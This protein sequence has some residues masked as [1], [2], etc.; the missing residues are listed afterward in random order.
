MN[1]EKFEE[2]LNNLKEK[3]FIDFKSEMYFTNSAKDTSKSRAE[4]VKDI[5]SMWNTPRNKE[6]YVVIGV[7]NSNN[8]NELLGIDVNTIPDDANLRNQ[9][10]GLVT[11]TP[12]FNYDTINFDKKNFVVITIPIATSICIV[13][14]K[15]HGETLK[16]DALYYRE[17]S[18][19]NEA[20]KGSEKE[21]EIY[22][23]FRYK[24]SMV[25]S[26]INVYTP[27]ERLTSLMENFNSDKYYYFLITS[28]LNSATPNLKNF[29]LV[30]W[31]F[32]MDFDPNSQNS[33]LLFHCRD[34]LELNRSLHFVVKGETSSIYNRYGTYWYF[35]SGLYGRNE[36]LLPDKSRNTWLRIYRRDF[37]KQ[38][39]KILKALGNEKPIKIL[40]VV[41]DNSI[42]DYLSMIFDSFESCHDGLSFLIISPDNYQS[43]NT[44]ASDRGFEFLTMPLLHLC[45]TF[46]NCQDNSNIKKE[47]YFIPSSSGTEIE[48]ANKKIP[49]LKE[50]FEIVHLGTGAT[51][52]IENI[53]NRDFLRGHEISWENL[54]FNHDAERDELKKLEHLVLEGLNNRRHLKINFYHI[55]G[56]GG[57]TVARRIL[58]NCHKK[59]PCVVLQSMK[60]PLETMMRLSHIYDI[61]QSSILLLIDGGLISDRQSEVLDEKI[62]SSHLPVITLQMIRRFD[63]QHAN[64]PQKNSRVLLDKLSKNEKD[65]FYYLLSK[66]ISDDKRDNLKKELK[67]DCTPF[68]LG[69]FI[70][71]NEYVGIDNYIKYRL[72]NINEINKKIIVFLSVAYYYGQRSISPQ[73]FSDIL[74][75]SSTRYIDLKDVFND[76]KIADIIVYDEFK[77]WRISHVIFAERCLSYLL[78]PQEFGKNN[79]H[80]WKQNL[81]DTAKEFI[82]FCR[83]NVH[84]SPSDESLEIIYRVFYF[85]DNSELLGTEKSE[86]SN[87]I[88]E[89]NDDN[90]KQ[91]VF[92]YLTDVF[93]DEAQFWAHLSRFYRLIK[94]DSSNALDAI[95]HALT[96]NDNDNLI[97]HGKGMVIWKKI[98]NLIYKNTAN[99]RNNLRQIVL[100]A[101]KASLCFAKCREINPVDEYGYISE[102]QMIIQVLNHAGRHY[103]NKPID[104]VTSTEYPKWLRESIE[105]ASYLLAQVRRIRQDT[106][107]NQLEANCQADLDVINQDIE[108]A[109]QK[110]NRLLESKQSSPLDKVSIRRSII[111]TRLRQ[112][113]NKWHDLKGKDVKRIIELL[114]DNLKQGKN[115]KDLRLWLNAIRVFSDPPHLAEITEKI[116][117]WRNNINS[118]DAVYYLYIM[119]VLQVLS[120][121]LTDFGKA[122]ANIKE[123]HDRSRYIRKNDASF[124]W[125]GKG[126]GIKQL[127]HWE[128][129]GEWDN[130]FWTKPS[131]LKR[132][133]G[134][135]SSI[136]G[137][138]KGYIEIE[139][140]G[141]KAFFV[142]GQRFNKS[143]NNRNIT[144]YLGFSYSGLRAWEV[145]L[146]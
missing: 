84:N 142:P 62:A 103:N 107:I 102:V 96:L 68:S 11:Y 112:A 105:N 137:P 37:E 15:F 106:K 99:D 109:L 140:T 61:S 129:L 45:Q 143:S 127:I 64:L 132:L 13:K 23:W 50:E 16:K 1:S 130:G 95:D 70:F 26:E 56:G 125:I 28:P 30:S 76:S 77:K 108:G 114:E 86:F 29:G 10:E 41:E 67:N 104:A 110:W 54:R 36:T 145:E 98:S 63:L 53:S 74:G 20:L 128:N 97:Y 32:V 85:R 117:Y 123:C 119:Q 133:N 134:V 120:G 52:P 139:G 141:F 60:D 113:N 131:S 93:P 38:I 79:E 44:I 8:K 92:C 57:S 40:I 6:A 65:N 73:W 100:E 21:K 35:A 58:W 59:Y 94:H 39:D 138:A 135:I 18:V 144:C 116:T 46:E 33:G 27:N 3:D 49:W 12:Q 48:I 126:D 17:G 69:F 121:S 31:T 88:K 83:G 34:V 81:S 87:F 25:G 72:E 80:I 43:L 118:L 5:V 2:L 47:G 55:P 42:Y 19:N 146:Y 122:E 91:E 115:D 14:K 111:Y 90:G 4:F 101:E 51:I 22:T 9:F 78:A 66:E 89:I 75:V 71:E 24:G 136:D 124:E 7:K 82:S